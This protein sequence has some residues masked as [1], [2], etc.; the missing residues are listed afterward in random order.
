MIPLLGVREASKPSRV[1]ESREAMWLALV[2]IGVAI[3]LGL[4]L[5]PRQALP[6]SV[7]LPMPDPGAL[8]RAAAVDH[9]LAEKARRESLPANIRALGSALRE[10]HLVEVG[11]EPTRSVAQMRQAID[12][13]T[14]QAL[15]GGDETLLQLRAVQLESFLAE[16]RRFEATRTQSAELVSVAGGFVHSMETEGW[17]DGRS[18]EASDAAL[19]AMFKE[20][21][22]A[23]VGL[24]KRESFR[25]PL[26]EERA[27]YALYLAHPHAAP[28]MRDAVAAARRGARDARTCEAVA[29]LQRTA[30]ETWRIERISRLAAIDPQYPAAYARGIANLRRGEYA[31]AVDDLSA[32]LRDHPDGPLTL[33]AH[34]YLRAAVAASRVQ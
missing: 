7:P 21:W 8:A 18:F 29:V 26:D 4:L 5:F 10:L 1:R 2:P 13:L 22:N 17:Y 19:R 24:D 14:A 20:M 30:V 28:A 11:A 15:A 34:N 32:W 33:R 27:L 6:D 25:P 12:S 16:A 31:R 3:T 9:D 23:V